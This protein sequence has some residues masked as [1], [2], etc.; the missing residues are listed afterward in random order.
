MWAAIQSKLRAG[1][2]GPEAGFF[3]GPRG[4]I[5][6]RGR[7]VLGAPLHRNMGLRERLKSFA[8]GFGSAAE[9][10]ARPAGAIGL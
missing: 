2:K 3:S 6:G 5:E 8:A 1:E 7:M 9:T 10:T 4:M